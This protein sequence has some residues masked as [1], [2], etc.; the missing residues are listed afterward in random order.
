M[1]FRTPMHGYSLACVAAC[2]LLFVYGASAGERAR[3]APRDDS[4]ERQVR[5]A[6]DVEIVFQALDR[7]G[8]QRISRREAQRR[9]G[10][11]K[12]FDGVDASEDGYLSLAEF[13]ARPSDEPFE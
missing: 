7:D 5:S 10:L 13:R 8:D 2:T 6:Q 11:G 4:A 12:R 9:K 1:T 3:E